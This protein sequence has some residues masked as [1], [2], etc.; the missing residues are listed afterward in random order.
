MHFKAAVVLT[1]MPLVPDKPIDFGLQ[2]FCKK[3]LICADYCPGNAISH[4]EKTMHNGYETW[5][6]NEQRCHSFRVMN[7]KGT[8]C[9]RCIKVCPWTRP[10][11]FSHNLIR[12]AVQRSG[13][14]R[15]F[16]IQTS[17]ILK[18]D[19]ANLEDKW[20][21]DIEEV[22]GKLRIPPDLE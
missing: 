16:A 19:K 11:T 12:W 20:W 7:K 15:R 4:G 5:K 17:K 10:N 22:D 6:L 9:G 13:I 18:P 3:C 1:D 2:D 14:A 8:Y 21:F